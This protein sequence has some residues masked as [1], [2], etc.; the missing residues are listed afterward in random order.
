MTLSIHDFSAGFSGSVRPKLPSGSESA[1]PSLYSSSM[2]F[3]F[4]FSKRMDSW[5]LKKMRAEQNP[6]L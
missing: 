2:G 1:L 3:S 4:F 6:Q 5:P